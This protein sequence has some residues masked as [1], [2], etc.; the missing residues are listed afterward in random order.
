MTVGNRTPY[1]MRGMAA[2]YVDCSDLREFKR[3]SGRGEA[4]PASA[5]HGR[6]GTLSN[7]GPAEPDGAAKATQFLQAMEQA[8]APVAFV[9]NTTGYIAG[10][11][12]ERAGMIK[13]GAKMTRALTSLRAPK[14]ALCTGVSFGPGIA[15]CA[16]PP[17][18]RISC[19][20]GPTR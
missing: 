20:P 9:N 5:D 2:R 3:R 17:L 6:A 16:A 4:L 1:G 11:E 13:Q 7:N 10:T 18:E 14:V 12:F 19:S 8:G 15:E